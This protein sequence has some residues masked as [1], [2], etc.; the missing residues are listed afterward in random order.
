MKQLLLSVLALLAAVNLIAQDDDRTDSQKR[1]ETF[2]TSNKHEVSL[3]ITS[4]LAIPAFSP[5]YEYI[6]GRYSGVGIDL[7]ISL[8]D[9]DLDFSDYGDIDV[10]KF[11]RCVER[12]GKVAVECCGHTK[13]N[14]L[15]FS[16]K[17]EIQ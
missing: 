12:L 10:D 14:S 17:T 7:F 4:I 2:A 11:E 3:D 6:L 1:M 9:D 5:R 16:S 8:E 13:A 15:I